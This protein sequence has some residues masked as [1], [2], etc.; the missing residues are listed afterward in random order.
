MP[1]FAI[2][3]LTG[4]GSRWHWPK[5]TGVHFVLLGSCCYYIQFIR[6]LGRYPS[7]EYSVEIINRT[8][9]QKNYN[10]FE[11]YHRHTWRQLYFSFTIAV[12]SNSGA[13]TIGSFLVFALFLSWFFPTVHVYYIFRLIDSL[14]AFCLLLPSTG[15]LYSIMFVWTSCKLCEAP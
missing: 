3:L 14:P 6:W 13:F 12:H 1:S 15:R 11:A 5:W 9:S 10:Q 2:S 4:G 8:E 7:C